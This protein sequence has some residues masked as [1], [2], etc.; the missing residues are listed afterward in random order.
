MTAAS[1]DNC[2]LVMAGK[3]DLAFSYTDVA[4][5]AYAGLDRFKSSG[6][7][8]ACSRALAMLYPGYNHIVTIEG[9][10]IQEAKDL[11]GSGFPPALPGAARRSWR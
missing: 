5:S 4:Y 10:G 7:A 11:K 1:V 9:R 2:K 8:G 3:S 6:K